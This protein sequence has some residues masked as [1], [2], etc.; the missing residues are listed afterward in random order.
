MNP[1]FWR[2]PF[3]AITWRRLAH[4]LTGAVLAPVLLIPLLFG[5][6]VRLELARARWIGAV[7]GVRPRPALYG[8]ANL[9]LAVPFGVFFGYLCLLWP[10]WVSYPVVFW[11]ADLAHGTWGGPT[12]L[13]AFAVHTS[14]AL[15]MLFVG[16][17]LLKQAARAHAAVVR[18]LL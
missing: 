1:S 7:P 15:V 6:G 8:L 12:R 4:V 17:W 10:Y 3:A 13:G 11:D 5:W 14:P 18:R 9:A 16:P 2:L